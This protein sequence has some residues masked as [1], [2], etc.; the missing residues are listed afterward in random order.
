MTSVISA[1]TSGSSTPGRGRFDAYAFLT[2]VAVGCL[3]LVDI[4]LP[5][6][7]GSNR[8]V[9][10]AIFALLIFG[11]MNVRIRTPLCAAVAFL[12]PLY[13]LLPPL[14]HPDVEAGDFVT[15][16]V[17][18]MACVAAAVLL[19][20]QM[21]TERRRHRLI[22]VF[23]VLAVA[24]AI[25]AVFQRYGDLG[26]LGRDRW[27]RYMTEYEA[28]RGTGFL[29]DPNFLAVP[30]ASVVPLSINWRFTQLR[31]PATVVLGAGVYATDSRAGILLTVLALG[32]STASR[33]TRDTSRR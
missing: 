7:G 1:A 12:L 25:V 18:Q 5:V 28:L 26:P 21:T 10:I 6:V 14:V 16:F 8:V 29:A 23:V 24:A 31:W 22:D 33:L 2:S 9:A 15:V 13:F 32:L 27:G 3:F 4:D 17:L 11:R 20:R 19:A 30:L